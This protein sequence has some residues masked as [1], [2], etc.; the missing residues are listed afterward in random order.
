MKSDESHPQGEEI[1]KEMGVVNRRENDF[2][3]RE[4]IV[5]HWMKRIIK[6]EQSRIPPVGLGDQAIGTIHCI[7]DDI[8]GTSRLRGKRCYV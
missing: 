2:K 6:T 4:V 1:A 7:R 3:K 5:I 8:K